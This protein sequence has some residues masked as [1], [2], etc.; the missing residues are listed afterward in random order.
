MV[1]GHK[2]G[3]PDSWRVVPLGP[4]AGRRHLLIASPT[5]CAVLA[6]APLPPF[7]LLALQLLDVQARAFRTLGRALLA[8]VPSR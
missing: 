2:A 1:R 4:L 8:L 7:L 5:L 6:I 3:P